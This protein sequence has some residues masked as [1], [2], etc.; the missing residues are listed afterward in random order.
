MI[1][2]KTQGGLETAAEMRRSTHLKITD[3]GTSYTSDLK[4]DIASGAFSKAA[5]GGK[6]TINGHVY[7]FAHPDYWLNCG[8][9]PCTRHH[10]LVV[11]AEGL[12][13]AQMHKT[14]SGQYEAGAANTTEGGYIGSDMKKAGGGLEQAMAVIQ[15]D[16]GAEN[17]LTHREKLVNAVTN[18]RPSASA[19]YDSTVELMNECMVYG[20][21][22][23]TPGC[24]GATVAAN[25][26]VDRSQLALFALR[27]D[28]ICS[29]SRKPWWLR[30]IAT[31]AN[32]VQIAGPGEAM[33]YG[34]TAPLGV[35]PV[36]GVC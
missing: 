19:W 8:D 5:V 1:G 30:D 31:S 32:F 18:G 14:V 24:D 34:A 3:L 36:F 26:T 10:M 2:I 23:L 29:S 20:S 21:H 27:P 13:A 28:L 17:I 16:F 4:K 6:L 22:I 11:P 35:R 9:S 7:Y 12:V 15:A 33:C 25:F